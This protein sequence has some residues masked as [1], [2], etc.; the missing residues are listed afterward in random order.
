FLLT[1]QGT[2]RI[3][4]TGRL[5]GSATT[6]D[7]SKA[8]MNEVP[9]IKGKPDVVAVRV[10][11]KNKIYIV[12]DGVLRPVSKARARQVNGGSMPKVHVI[13]KI[14]KKQFP[15]GSRL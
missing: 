5:R 12:R 2:V 14:T 11:K 13:L 1:R 10:R 3:D 9:R 6:Q 7:W 15:V 8:L 4:G